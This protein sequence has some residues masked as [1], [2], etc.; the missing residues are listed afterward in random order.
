MDQDDIDIKG[1]IERQWRDLAE[2]YIK[3][4]DQEQGYNELV[5]IPRLLRTIGEVG[6]LRILDAGCGAGDL[7]VYYAARGAMV[8]AVDI[9]ERMIEEARNRASREALSIEFLLADMEELEMLGD[10]SFD[11]IICLVAVAG[12]LNEIMREFGR[13]L[14]EDGK[15]YF[16][17]VHPML[18]KGYQEVIDGKPCLVTSDY[19]DRSIKKT[20][21]P[22]GPAVNGEEIPFFWKNY[23]LQDYF[24]ALA[25]SGFLVEQFIEPV[26]S[27]GKR[28]NVQKVA[29]A[30]SYPFFFLIQAVK[31]H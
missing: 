22:F 18:N 10:A 25:H 24:D 12:R 17:D 6:D 16:G 19:F 7:A 3:F 11:I 4:R 1:A 23:T 26:P 29:K 20:V 2:T 5:L 8:T 13:L 27:P 31:K 15:L 28:G 30:N 14:R 9:S 21:N